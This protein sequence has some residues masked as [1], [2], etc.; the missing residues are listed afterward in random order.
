M[1]KRLNQEIYQQLKVIAKK[2][3]LRER[4][5]HTLSPTDLVH[6]AFLKINLSDEI[7]I[8]E[9]QYTFILARQMRRLLVDYGRQ[10]SAAKRGGDRKRIMY[11]D[12]LGISNNA[13]TDFGAINDAIE[14]LE[15]M[16]KRAASA[17]DLFYFTN[18]NKDRA[19]Q[20]LDISVPT[21]E[22]DLRFAKAH[23]SHFL[24]ELAR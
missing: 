4:R 13:V 6:E 5:G 3:M 21:L 8:K 1:E 24:S 17:I 11:T 22:R 23:I 14:S 15:A 16:D 18:I 19:A 20:L 2:L 12:A 10:K 7:D 9:D